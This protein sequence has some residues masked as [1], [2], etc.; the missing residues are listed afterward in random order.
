MTRAVARLYQRCGLSLQL[1]STAETAGRPAYLIGAI[2]I[3]RS[4]FTNL[5]G[6]AHELLAAVTWLGA[7]AT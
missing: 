7:H 3:T 2:E 1:L 4:T 5:G 6:D